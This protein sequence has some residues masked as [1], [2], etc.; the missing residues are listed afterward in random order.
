MAPFE[1]AEVET[2]SCNAGSSRDDGLLWSSLLY[3]LGSPSYI[4]MPT[5]FLNSWLTPVHPQLRTLDFS[6]NS[7]RTCQIYLMM[8]L[9]G[10]TSSWVS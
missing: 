1:A 2:F 9:T 3:L 6:T 8:N 4:A 7:V 5:I 10:M